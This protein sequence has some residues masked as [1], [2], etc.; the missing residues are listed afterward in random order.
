[1]RWAT[2]ESPKMGRPLTALL[3]DGL[4]YAMPADV[5][6]IDLIGDSERLSEA[7]DQA[8]TAPCEVIRP[9][10]VRLLAPI[11]QPPSVRDFMAFENHYLTSTAALNVPVNPLFYE[12][13]VYYFSNPAAVVGPEEHVQLAPGTAQYDYEL[14]VA[15]VIGRP[16]KNLTPEEAEAHIAGYTI[17]CDWSARDLQAAEMTFAIGLAKGKDTA[18]SLGPYL[19]TPDELEPLRNGH[20]FDLAMTATVN[21]TEYSSGNWSSLYWPFA[22]MLAYASRGTEL[23]T[24]DVIGSGTVGTGCILEL[25][26]VHGGERYPWLEV[27][28]EVELTVERLGSIRA[29]MVPAD[30]VIPLSQGPQPAATHTP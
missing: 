12:Q 8:F 11:P 10:D 28:D 21:G 2:Y 17:L 26:R 1:M 15:A 30:D 22:D 4:L 20:G 27:G 29:T 16:G 3:R 5:E 18:T 6:L 14:E 25:S 13:P 7:A 23:R 24:G 19:V 9:E